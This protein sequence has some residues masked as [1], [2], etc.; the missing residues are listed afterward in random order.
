MNCYN[1]DF[2]Q[3][4]NIST[5]TIVPDGVI[6]HHI[7][8]N[9]IDTL[10]ILTQEQGILT[11]GDAFSGV[12]AHCIGWKDGSRTVLAK[13]HQRCWHAG[14]SEFLGRS[15]CND[16]MLGYEFHLD[17]YKEQ[18]TQDQIGSFIEWLIPRIDIWN[19]T[20]DY[21]TDH[22]TIAPTRKVDLNPVELNRLLKAIK[23]LFT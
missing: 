22:R 8:L 19:F 3:T 18:L 9:K 17:S 2:V 1:E 5:R 14:R 4:K 10:K 23:P 6:L 16:F 21:M 7:S 13:D 12:S 11:N 15:G 20:F